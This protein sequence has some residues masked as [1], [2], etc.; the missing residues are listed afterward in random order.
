MTT[1]I[2]N[3]EKAGNSSMAVIAELGPKFA[4]RAAKHDADGTFVAENFQEMREH[5]LFSAAIPVELGGG[6]ASHA[7]MCQVL[8]ELA[9]YDGATA[10][11]FSMHSHLLATLNFRVRNNMEPS[12]EPALRRIATEEL[13]LVSTGG[14]DW[15]EGSGELTK[16]DGGYQFS[17]RKIFGSGSPAG[18]LLLT[19]GVYNDLE[20]GPSVMHF[21]VN[22]HDA[23]VTV[24]Q[25]WDTM[26]MRGTGSNS[27]QIENVFVPEGGISLTRPQGV[28]HRF[29]DVI[30]PLA[31]SLIMSVYLGIAE[32]ARD[33]AVDQAGK[34]RDDT[35]VQDQVGELDNELLIAQT[36][37]GEMI[38]MATE[39]N[40]PSLEQS[41]LI[42]RH[43]TIATNAAIRT[44]EKSLAVAGGQAYFRGL[45]LERRFRDVQAA[46]FHPIQEKRQHRFSGRIAL[47]LDPIE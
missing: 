5:K 19:T 32:S 27:V 16:V 20:A 28:W 7:D 41:N 14:S 43:K 23:G 35:M 8:R 26:G 47:G 1:T 9:R 31:L 30:S 40:P 39:Y 11:S 10:L 29:F 25:D 44:V 6:G 17:G 3:T 24:M 4:S 15:L 42:A 12:S 37:I 13:V 38:R 22:M 33:I 34:K 45:G 36:S 18:D 21:A 46:R 2:N